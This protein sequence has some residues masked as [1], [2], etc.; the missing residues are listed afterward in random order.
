MS[1]KATECAKSGIVQH[2]SS[3]WLLWLLCIFLT[4]SISECIIQRQKWPHWDSRQRLWGSPGLYLI[5]LPPLHF[6]TNSDKNFYL[7]DVINQDQELREAVKQLYQ[8]TVSLEGPSEQRAAFLQS[9]RKK[10]FYKDDSRIFTRRL[11]RSCILL[12]SL[13]FVVPTPGRARKFWVPE[14]S[15]K[16]VF[17]KRG[18]KGLGILVQERKG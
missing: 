10:R 16:D 17:F 7:I 1:E 18:D 13:C 4:T 8:K 6:H 3:T 12:Q 2:C 11:R 9:W 14:T 5:S 15:E